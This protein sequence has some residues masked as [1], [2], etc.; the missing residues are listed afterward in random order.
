MKQK[1]M[2][3]ITEIL[4]VYAWLPLASSVLLNLIT[5]YG[6]RLIT[7]GMDHYEI[8]F[9]VDAKIPFW[10]PAIVIYILCYVIWPLGFV[11]GC[12]E[13]KE[14]CY[15]MLAGEMIAKL[16]CLVIFLTVPTTITRPE[17]TGTDIFSKLTAFIY[18]K[19]TPD[20]LLPSIHCL[21][22]WMLFRGALWCRKVGTGYKIGYGIF[23]LMV[24]ASTLLVKQHY[25]VDVAAAL[26]VVE[27]GIFL[28]DRLKAWRVFEYV[29][30]KIGL[31]AE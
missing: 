14:V 16:F 2:K 25:I 8:N 19:D 27:L 26:I 1:F 17:V 18:W 21:E 20:N 6:S 5:Y 23:S 10:P 12:R 9:A 31:Q 24:F 29:N 22:S 28:A 3:K 7:T 30:K 4:P 11:V 15:R 13:S